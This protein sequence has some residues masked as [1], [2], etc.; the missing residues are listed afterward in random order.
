MQYHQ[1][2]TNNPH[3]K[4]NRASS[5]AEQELVSPH[6][7][8]HYAGLHA[9]DTPSITAADVCQ[10]LTQRQMRPAYEEDELEASQRMT[11]LAKRY[12]SIPMP[13]GVL[14]Q[15]GNKQVY[16]HHSQPPIQRAS[17]HQTRTTEAV[18]MPK[19][20]RRF[21]W[22][23]WVGLVFLV[24]LI[25]YVGLGA[26]GVWWQIHSDDTTYGRPR[27][28]QA[29]AVVGHGDSALHPSH[30][31]AMNLNRHIMILEI[32][33][34]DVARSIIYT[35]PTLMGDGQDLTPVTLTFAD[36]NG[37]GHPDMLV[38]MLDQTLVFLNNGTKFVPP[39]T[40]MS[41][42]GSASPILGGKP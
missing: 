2:T 30:F 31:V 19:T 16:V 42:V 38:H 24:M 33:G 8:G 23:F 22:A 6:R 27:T 35:G 39:S 21:H 17:R 7:A 20:H 25:G 37:D 29:D 28:F 9:E 12:S 36:E 34:G 10:H 40:T 18:H 4:K 3:V 26:F 15:Q 13:D 1:W 5:Q 41:D 32:P 14:Y 11:S